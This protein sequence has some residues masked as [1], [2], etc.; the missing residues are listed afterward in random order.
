MLDAAIA[1]GCVDFVL[2]LAPIA[3]ALIT[4]VMAPTAAALPFP[5][6]MCT[7]PP[8]SWPDP[9]SFR[10]GRRRVKPGGT[11]M[12]MLARSF[13]RRCNPVAVPLACCK[14]ES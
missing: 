12:A 11:G 8:E 7:A 2:P 3:P 1:T 9:A 6:C 13:L 4:L 10:V 5:G 14:L